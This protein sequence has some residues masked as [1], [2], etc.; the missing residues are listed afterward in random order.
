MCVCGPLQAVPEEA[1]GPLEL[2][3]QLVMGSYVGVAA[4]PG[5]LGRADT[6]V[7]VTRA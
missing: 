4:E 3:S 1:L 5:F 6:A 2:E 7:N